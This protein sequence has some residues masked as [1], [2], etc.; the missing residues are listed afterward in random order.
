[1]RIIKLEEET[2]KNI[3]EDLLKRSPNSYGEFESRVADIVSN[4]K[5]NG[6]KALFEYTEK[7]DGCFLRMLF[8]V[9]FPSGKNHYTFFVS[10][11]QRMA[12]WYRIG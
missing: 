11:P 10:F 12:N 2:K 7:F 3:L 1:M 9:V 8:S 4:V 5:A 6:D